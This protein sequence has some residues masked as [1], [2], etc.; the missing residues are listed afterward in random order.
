MRRLAV[1][2][3]ILILLG[4]AVCPCKTRLQGSVTASM[5]WTWKRSPGLSPLGLISNPASLPLT[6]LVMLSKSHQ[7]SKSH[8]PHLEKG[9][10]A[11]RSL[12]VWPSLGYYGLGGQQHCPRGA[13]GA[14]QDSVL[15]RSL[16]FPGPDL[17]GCPGGLSL[18]VALPGA[19]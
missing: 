6:Y 17:Y 10:G 14:E 16:V 8:L 2:V 19:F 13:G 12:A 1:V 7:L 18:L 4:L 11:L 15:L 5:R 3:Q 9:R